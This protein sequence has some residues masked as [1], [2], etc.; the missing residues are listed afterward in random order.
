[1]LSCDGR[2]D[3]WNIFG[4]RRWTLDQSRVFFVVRGATSARRGA[5][6]TA[7]VPQFCESLAIIYPLHDIHAFPYLS[8][9][10]IQFILRRFEI[11]SECKSR[12]VEILHNISNSPGSHQV[13]TGT[14]SLIQSIAL[15]TEGVPIALPLA[16]THNLTVSRIRLH[17]SISW[18]LLVTMA[19]HCLLGM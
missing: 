14:M 18:F 17:C 6:L 9:V 12:L 13:D 15:L 19:F 16:A 1:M 2:D 5:V 10:G 4:A 11:Q 8:Q 3:R 7:C